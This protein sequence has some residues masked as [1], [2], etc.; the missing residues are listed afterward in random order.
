VEIVILLQEDAITNFGIP[1][2]L[3]DTSKFQSAHSGVAV[4]FR[5]VS[6]Q[7][8]VLGL[9]SVPSDNRN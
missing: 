8:T 5:V 7:A 6:C 9:Y 3:A 2:T 1:A 4:A